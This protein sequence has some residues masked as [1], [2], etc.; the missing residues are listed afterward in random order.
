MQLDQLTAAAA[1]YRTTSF[2]T[3]IL[4]V[5]L[6]TG[7]EWKPLGSKDELDVIKIVFIHYCTNWFDMKKNYIYA[8]LAM[9]CVNLNTLATQS[10]QWCIN[11][12]CFFPKNDHCD[13]WRGTL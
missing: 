9:W 8:I 1:I 13:K 6:K 4:K 3:E 5:I 7:E 11:Q 2:H 10:K 12:L